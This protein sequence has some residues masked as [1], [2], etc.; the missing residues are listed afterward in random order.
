MGVDSTAGPSKTPGSQL[1]GPDVE[2]GFGSIARAK[3]STSQPDS[4]RVVSEH[5]SQKDRQMDKPGGPVWVLV[6][7]ESGRQRTIQ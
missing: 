6:D 7:L 2:G 1:V 4:A 3:R 5:R